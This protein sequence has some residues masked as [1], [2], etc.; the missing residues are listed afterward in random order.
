MTSSWATPM[1]RGDKSFQILYCSVS[2]VTHTGS[3]L[4]RHKVQYTD[5]HHARYEEITTRSLDETWRILKL[6]SHSTCN[7]NNRR[8]TDRVPGWEH[9]ARGTSYC[10]GGKMKT[11]MKI[12][13]IYQMAVDYTPQNPLFS[14]CFRPYWNKL[15]QFWV[16][17]PTVT[18]WKLRPN[19]GVSE[20]LECHTCRPKL[21]SNL[22]SYF[23]HSWC[24]SDIVVCQNHPV[25][26]FD[27]IQGRK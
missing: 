7:N 23:S 5:C 20:Q 22:F 21:K 14:L 19:V 26:D 4:R 17:Y 10:N 2:S 16:K 24:N 6:I 27:Q 25:L 9:T 3:T 12:N 1:H 13:T 8:R 15:L 11:K 18:W